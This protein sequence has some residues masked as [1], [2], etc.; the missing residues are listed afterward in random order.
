[1]VALWGALLRGDRKTLGRLFRWEQGRCRYLTPEDARPDRLESEDDSSYLRV[2][3]PVI[4]DEVERPQVM[5]ELGIRRGEVIRAGWAY[6]ACL[7]DGAMRDLV[8]PR[9]LLTPGKN[10]ALLQAVPA[11]LLGAMWWQFAQAVHGD[12]KYLCCPVCRKWVPLSPGRHRADSK[13]CSDYCR[14]VAYRGRQRQAQEL[15]RRG[16]TPQQIAERLGST[17]SVVKGWIDKG[18]GGK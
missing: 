15:H 3:E 16:R 10:S 8:R 4:F 1:L 5:K 2:C 11:S 9:L 17:V 6:L 14:L 13:T 12:K 18:K 7:I